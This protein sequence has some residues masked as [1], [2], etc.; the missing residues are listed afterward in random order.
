LRAGKCEGFEKE[1]CPTT[2]VTPLPVHVGSMETGTSS[3]KN[4]TTAV[5]Y[6]MGLYY[7]KNMQNNYKMYNIM[8]NN[9][10]ML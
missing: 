6:L 9:N 7:N 2:S 4:D 1:E 10:I 3:G 8:Q 5:G